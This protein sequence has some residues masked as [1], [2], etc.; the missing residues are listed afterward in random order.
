M[1]SATKINQM[2]QNLPN[3][4]VLLSAWLK[5]QGYSFSLQQNYRQSGW[6]RSIGKG[7]MVRT[8]QTLLLF[9]AVS[10]LQ[11]QEG[12][13]VHI[14][15]RTALGL[16]GY[17]H[18]LEINKKDTLL[19][20]S[21]GTHIP[22]WLKNN[23]WDSEPHIV[24]T[25]FLPAETGLLD[26]EQNG[27]TVKIAS[28]A[29]AIM[30]CLILAPDKF[31][32][33]EAWEIIQGLSLLKPLSVNELLLQC[34]SVKVKRLFMHFARKAGHAWFN[35]INPDNIDLGKGKRSFVSNGVYLPDYM[36]TLPQHL[37]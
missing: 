36:I 10:A 32:L 6:L 12:L 2:L 23:I 16:S 5:E 3:G 25:N 28:P 35:K 31:D 4:A 18:Y 22:S 29:R 11:S 8:G 37:G 13:A 17:A 34:K 14:G 7:A 24:E 9:G 30:E 1:T 19:F 26:F 27:I 21:R 15:G 33:T 20:T